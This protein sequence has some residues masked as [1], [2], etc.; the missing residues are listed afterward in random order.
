[1]EKSKE[2]LIQ[3]LCDAHAMEEQAQ[4]MLSGMLHRIENY[5]ELSDRVSI[6]LSETKVQAERV[7]GCLEAF[8]EETSFMKDAAAKLFATAQIASGVFAGDE[9]L[10]GSLAGYSFE[11]MEIA[12]Y[13]M[14]S[15]AAE[16]CNES[17]VT[18]VCQQNLREEVAMA[19]WLHNHLS[20]TTTDFLARDSRK[21]V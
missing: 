9:V 1:M 8:G 13:T 3:W 20:S 15:A 19:E 17:E 10:K 14:L 2:W 4:T 11:H 6:H 21:P 18:L 5:P 12:S 7:R 16:A